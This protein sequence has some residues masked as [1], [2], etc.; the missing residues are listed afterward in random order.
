M[1]LYCFYFCK[2]EQERRDQEPVRSS[3][4]REAEQNELT[5]KPS[6]KPRVWSIDEQIAKLTSTINVCELENELIDH[7]C[8]PNNDAMNT[9]ALKSLIASS[10][11][12]MGGK[13]FDAS[14]CVSALA[15]FKRDVESLKSI[16]LYEPTAST[17]LEDD[18]M[19]R[20]GG[21]CSTSNGTEGQREVIADAV[22]RRQQKQLYDFQNVAKSNDDVTVKLIFEILTRVEKLEEG[23][24]EIKNKLDGNS[25]KNQRMSNTSI[26]E[27]HEEN[28]LNDDEQEKANG[29]RDYEQLKMR[30]CSLKKGLL[31]DEE[32]RVQICARDGMELEMEFLV[33]VVDKYRRQ[34][35]D[36]LMLNES[37]VEKLDATC[38]E[39]TRLEGKLEVA[40]T[41]AMK[42]IEEKQDVWG[43]KFEEILDE[44]AGHVS[45]SSIQT[46]IHEEKFKMVL[47]RNAEAEDRF[48]ELSDH[49]QEM[50]IENENV[51][52]ELTRLQEKM[53]EAEV[54][55][56]NSESLIG[57][58]KKESGSS[59]I[60]ALADACKVREG[61]PKEMLIHNVDCDM[62]MDTWNE[63]T[64]T[65]AKTLVKQC[66]DI[67]IQ[68]S[69]CEETLSKEKEKWEDSR[70]ELR[71]EIEIE[72]KE[73]QKTLETLEKNE[74]RIE[75]I[76][77]ELNA[78]IGTL[79]DSKESIKTYK[80]KLKQLTSQNED[81]KSKLKDLKEEI[82][83]TNK[84]KQDIENLCLELTKTCDL[85]VEK[86]DSKD[87]DFKVAKMKLGEAL[88]EIKMLKSE[89]G[90]KKCIEEILENDLAN[91]ITDQIM[92][93]ALQLI[94]SSKDKDYI[95]K[96]ENDVE[97]STEKSSYFLIEIARKED[98]VKDL[99]KQTELLKNEI[100]NLRAQN[101][102]ADPRLEVDR[103]GIGK[104]NER[105]V[106][107]LTQGSKK[108]EFPDDEENDLINEDDS[109]EQITISCNRF[110]TKNS[111]C[112]DI[113]NK[114]MID[115]KVVAKFITNVS[116]RNAITTLHLEN[117]IKLMEQKINSLI[118]QNRVKE[119]FASNHAL[120]HENEKLKRDF[121]SAVDNTTKKILKN[122]Y[123][124]IVQGVLDF[125]F[126]E[127]ELEDSETVKQKLI[128]LI[129]SC[130]KE[131]SY[132]TNETCSK[133]GKKLLHG[134]SNIC[135]PENID[136]IKDA[137]ETQ[138]MERKREVNRLRQRRDQNEFERQNKK[139]GTTEDKGING[140]QKLDEM[141]TMMAKYI[142]GVVISRALMQM[143]IDSEEILNYY[144]SNSNTKTKKTYNLSFDNE[145]NFNEGPLIVTVND[146]EESA[147]TK[148]SML[149]II[150]ECD[151]LLMHE[152][153][154]LKDL[155]FRFKT[156]K[157]IKNYLEHAKRKREEMECASFVS[158]DGSSKLE[159]DEFS[160]E[161][162]TSC[163]E[164]GIGEIQN[165]SFTE[166]CIAFAQMVIKRSLYLF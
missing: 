166:D 165:P 118:R 69:E 16:L 103:K 90:K 75:S 82:N 52:G 94:Q 50:K 105:M 31:L 49:L 64:S 55:R 32:G 125:N 122:T 104:E 144:L 147:Q 39:N 143:G 76:M 159:S 57:R 40:Y 151:P 8:F 77:N 65:I 23:Y 70:K 2:A 142:C 91:Y 93:N 38:H 146:Y 114:E 145:L 68:K 164:Q 10:S 21:T 113:I 101:C 33:E 133:V 19:N 78:T 26:A 163:T 72:R 74:K 42:F 83:K 61:N 100:E 56:E 73:K 136:G 4:E 44:F 41:N 131:Y 1:V 127:E 67:A 24:G 88:D 63:L 85:L 22:V 89:L 123:D 80:G 130:L 45:K 13:A 140:E 162:I 154:T 111:F 27:M 47:E 156:A 155:F 138:I 102:F 116:V 134:R 108:R 53:K 17:H 58:E 98:D 43:I 3:N 129:G 109:E 128:V 35:E 62:A 139:T 11:T 153:E 121:K 81:M 95:N 97:K 115:H 124:S 20:N 126:K 6:L 34:N 137:F 117:C 152:M 107:N 7:Q 150:K 59:G 141:R 86:F 79:E 160:M 14:D 9:T 119:I 96:L 110:P 87:E 99:R 51:T 15:S 132:E 18:A 106:T 135:T 60:V 158:C 120:M 28:L 92:K 149:T 48:V 36:L 30:G 25:Q 46:A 66:I 84:E 5:N 71:D 29:E 12:D 161:S 148:Q 37:M 54:F 112:N 157:L